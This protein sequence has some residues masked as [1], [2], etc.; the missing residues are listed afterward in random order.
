MNRVIRTARGAFTLIELL[1]AMSLIV[2]LTSL[3]LMAVTNINERDGTTDA[4]GLTRQWLMTSKARAGRDNAPRGLRLVIGLD[5]NNIAKTS[6]FWVTE[7]QYI[8]APPVLIANDIITGSL[9]TDAAVTF[10]YTL[11]PGPP[12]A[13]NPVLGTVIGRQCQIVNL[14]LATAAQIQV[15]GLLQLPTLGTWHRITGV[16]APTAQPRPGNNWP[17]S[18][19]L[20]PTALTGR[21]TLT[22][23]LDTFPDAPLG[24]A[25]TFPPAAPGAQ[26]DPCFVTFHFGISAPPRPLLGEPPLQLPKGICIDVSPLIPLNGV[27][28][29]FA[30]PPSNPPVFVGVPQPD[31]DILFTPT[32]TVLP[33]SAGAATDGQIF[34]WHRDYTKLRNAPNGNN[35]LVVTGVAPVTYDMY[36]FQNGG[37]QQ[38]VAIRSKSGA[39][40]QFPVTW[41]NA[42]GQ[43]NPGEDPYTFARQG[44]TSP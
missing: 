29:P 9:Q 19:N 7:L 38:L 22:V 3:V 18:G 4:A 30:A 5:P 21:V 27:N 42:N 25:G 20:A 12:P 31:Y 40:G 17:W 41:P 8:E 26:A 32:G 39:L 10:T 33:F 14:D 15:N 35:A 23:N 6:Q 28:P 44:A 37:V 16:S 24:A 11:S 34:L 36:P 43:Y 13:G 2:L 1:V